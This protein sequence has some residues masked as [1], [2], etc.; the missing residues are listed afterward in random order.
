MTDAIRNS[1]ELIFR[2]ENLIETKTLPISIVQVDVKFRNPVLHPYPKSV[3][4]KGHDITTY[5]KPPISYFAPCS[6]APLSLIRFNTSIWPRVRLCEP[7]CSVL[8]VPTPCARRWN[9]AFSC[10]C[11]SCFKTWSMPPEC[12]SVPLCFLVVIGRL[13][14]CGLVV[15]NFGVS[16]FLRLV[17][18]LFWWFVNAEWLWVIELCEIILIWAFVWRRS[19]VAA[20][21]LIGH[22]FVC[23][24][25]LWWN[26]VGGLSFRLDDQYLWAQW[27]KFL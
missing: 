9:V 27:Y 25:T 1:Y 5:I 23:L 10:L 18:L 16:V 3:P 19:L 17:E 2:K 6:C 4:T 12:P 21:W 24:R 22:L 11:V 20:T 8:A 26:A 7:L 15:L 13:Y 14:M